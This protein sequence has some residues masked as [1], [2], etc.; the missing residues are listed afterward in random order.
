MQQLLDDRIEIA[1]TGVLDVA[2][3]VQEIADDI[4]GEV[5]PTSRGKVSSGQNGDRLLARL[6]KKWDRSRRPVGTRHCD[7]VLVCF[8]LHHDLTAG[9]H[10]IDIAATT[11]PSIGK[12]S[13]GKPSA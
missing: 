6:R 11:C 9:R 12:R 7:R 1:W 8:H 10:H 13:L 3:E 4:G 2:S 5:L